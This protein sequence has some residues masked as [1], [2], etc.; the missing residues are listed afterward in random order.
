MRHG[1]DELQY[2]AVITKYRVEG[3]AC[4]FF[5]LRVCEEMDV[6]RGKNVKQ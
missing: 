4:F 2:L 5:V 6:L 3:V 1:G